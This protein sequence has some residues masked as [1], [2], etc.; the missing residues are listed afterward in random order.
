MSV[1]R[2]TIR[3]EEE[4]GPPVGRSP[5]APRPVYA[6]TPLEIGGMGVEEKKRGESDYEIRDMQLDESKKG[7]IDLTNWHIQHLT[8]LLESERRMVKVL[9]SV[10]GVE[11]AGSPGGEVKR[12]GKD[13][14]V[15]EGSDTR[16]MPMLEDMRDG[17][18]EGP[19][20]PTAAEMYSHHC[21]FDDVLAPQVLEE[22]KER[23]SEAKGP[24]HNDL[25]WYEELIKARGS[26]DQ[27]AEDRDDKACRKNE[28]YL[29][30][31]KPSSYD[32]QSPYEDYQV[33]FNMLAE[34]NGWPGN[35]KALYL[36]GC[37]SGSARSVL[38]DM[39]PQ[40][41]YDYVKLD[42]AL[43]ERFGTDDQSELF[44]AKLRN[45]IKTKEETLQELAHDVRRLVRL[46]YPKAPVRT[47]EDLTKDQFIEALGDGEIRW[48]V[49]QARPKNITEALK[50][51]MEL[52]AFKESEKCRMRR[53]IRGIKV[54]EKELQGSQSQLG[55]PEPD[56]DRR[57]LPLDIQQMVA[58]INQMHQLGQGSGGPRAPNTGGAPVMEGREG[59]KS[60]GSGLRPS[61]DGNMRNGSGLNER[62]YGGPRVPFDVSR[63][64]CFR[65]DEMGHFARECPGLA[66]RDPGKMRVENGLNA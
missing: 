10:S 15:E 3:W 28:R 56:E 42:E 48:S 5:E 16:D 62:G 59:N 4:D 65:C 46:A 25:K 6:S 57:K 22:S 12:P 51:A 7:Y 55:E 27:K 30:R 24:I 8:E 36:A 50:V 18:M 17:N 64:K 63:I 21:K 32:G 40:D 37:L 38:N 9:S 53:S 43:R 39:E 35:V 31:M 33:Q 52:E 14:E 47:H 41:R 19:K 1:S 66:K 34:L 54:E 44:K 11:L 29:P 58:Q 2:G 20:K 49:F 61:I 60:S 26:R 13:R 23:A 45:R